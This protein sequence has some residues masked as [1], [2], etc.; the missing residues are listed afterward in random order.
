[1]AKLM[2]WIGILLG[3]MFVARLIAHKQAN[4]RINARKQ[5]AAND[6]NPGVNP[7]AQAKKRP[8]QQ[9]NAPETM[10]QCDHCGLHLPES[11]SI[12]ASGGTWC[13]DKHS[14]LGFRK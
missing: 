14:R 3:L 2:M 8:R 13:S 10:V 7:A 4:D 9:S 11:E 12:T 1:M 6:K 5:Q